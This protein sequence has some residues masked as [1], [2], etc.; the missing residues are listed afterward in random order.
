MGANKKSMKHEKS[1]KHKKTDLHHK[2]SNNVSKKHKN[3]L[4]V[5]VTQLKVSV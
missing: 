3:I 4:K 2:N 5:L 1:T